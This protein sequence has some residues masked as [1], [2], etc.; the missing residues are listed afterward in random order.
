MG[1]ADSDKLNLNRGDDFARG[2]LSNDA[3]WAGRGQ[4]VMWGGPGA[5]YFYPKRGRD[6]ILAGKGPD[7]IFLKP[8][9]VPDMVR[10]GLG[11]DKVLRPQDNDV[12]IDCEVVRKP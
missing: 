2:G 9:S 8:D 1:A 11:V 6:R 10:C 4:D 12:L 5:D 7:F 3:F